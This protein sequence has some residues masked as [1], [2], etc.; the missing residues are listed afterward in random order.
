[1][2]SYKIIKNAINE[3]GVKSISQD[4]GLS[5]SLL[6]KWCQSEYSGG[7]DNPLD[8]LLKL[9]ELTG[10]RNLVYWLCEQIG[11]FYT[12]NP[13]ASNDIS[14]ELFYT[15]QKILKEFSD[16]LN[17]IS[18]STSDAKIDLGEARN[19][20]SEWEELKRITETFVSACEKGTFDQ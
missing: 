19:I 13:P 9:Y 14:Q 20:R 3:V 5:S 10:D 17:A 8:R 6:Y 2:D 15:T 16:L 4:M 18:L 7:A 1:M 11:G 12:E